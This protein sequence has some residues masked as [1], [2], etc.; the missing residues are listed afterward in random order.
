MPLLIQ[1]RISLC[2]WAHN[3]CIPHPTMVLGG[4]VPLKSPRQEDFQGA[5]LLVL[6]KTFK[7]SPSFLILKRRPSEVKRDPGKKL[8]DAHAPVIDSLSPAGGRLVSPF[9]RAVA[10]EE[11]RLR[12]RSRKK[13]RLSRH[14]TLEDCGLSPADPCRDKR[15]SIDPIASAP[16][17]PGPFNPGGSF[18]CADPAQ[19]TAEPP[20]HKDPGRSTGTKM[21]PRWR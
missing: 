8:R 20:A 10:G 13:G 16:T 18:R 11:R 12:H 5:T 17:I 1:V 2:F 6:Q 9:L 7:V 21:P 4:K 3:T 19:A 15:P 14:E